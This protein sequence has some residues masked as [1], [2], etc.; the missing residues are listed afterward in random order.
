M[1]GTLHGLAVASQDHASAVLA[2]RKKRI[3]PEHP[4]P[5]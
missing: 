4:L 3:M 5:E 1:I 2:Q